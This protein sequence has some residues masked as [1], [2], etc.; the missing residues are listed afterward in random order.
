MFNLVNLNEVCWLLGIAVTRD[1]NKCTISL[2]QHV[3]IEKI[4]KRFDLEN[5]FPISTPLD[6]NVLLS[7]EQYPKTEDEK[8]QMKTIPYLRAIGLLMYAAIRTHI[9]IMYAAQCLS[10]FSSN[11]GQAHWT[12]V[13]WVI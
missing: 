9:D 12:T 1:R 8:K 4:A 13:Q 10:Q 6:P 11:R 5:T 3:Y 7:R 2:R